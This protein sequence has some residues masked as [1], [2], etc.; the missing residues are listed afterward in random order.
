[1]TCEETLRFYAAVVLPDTCSRSQ[2]R[3]RVQEV[4]GS[5]GLSSANKTLV[6]MH[7]CEGLNAVT[8]CSFVYII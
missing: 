1:M 7:S 3:A 6:S 4:L 2:L 8:F 5:V